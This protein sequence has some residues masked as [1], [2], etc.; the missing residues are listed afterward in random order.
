MMLIIYPRSISAGRRLFIHR[1]F[2]R[3]ALVAAELVD[4]K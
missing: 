2:I 1:L 3:Q 4:E